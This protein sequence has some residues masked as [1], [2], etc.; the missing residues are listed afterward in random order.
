MIV[1]VAVAGGL[2]A[3]ARF[4]VDGAVTSRSSCSVPLGTLCVN[5][6]GSCAL[7]FLTAWWTCQGGSG[8]GE[9]RPLLAVGFLGGYTTFSTACVES[10]RLAVDE[11]RKAALLL[12]LGSYAAS[13]FAA[14]LGFVAGCMC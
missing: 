10:V 5:V 3:M 13:L 12:A 7:G 4:V 1:A 9:L 2:G 11:R 14:G 8:G 6:S